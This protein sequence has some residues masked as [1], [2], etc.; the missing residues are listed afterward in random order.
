MTFNIPELIEARRDEVAAYQFNIDNY[1][2]A[3]EIAKEDPELAPFVEQLESLLKSE[4]YE[5]KKAKVMLKVMEAR[6][7]TSE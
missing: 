1:T 3:I 5:Q 4:L 2:I 7:C 6:S